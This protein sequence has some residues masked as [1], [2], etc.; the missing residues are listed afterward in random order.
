M[1]GTGRRHREDHRIRRTTT[2]DR[3]AVVVGVDTVAAEA[4]VATL[5]EVVDTT[6][7]VAVRDV[8]AAVEVAMGIVVVVGT[9]EAV[10]IEVAA[11]AGNAVGHQEGATRIEALLLPVEDI[12]D[13]PVKLILR[14]V[15]RSSLHS[16]AA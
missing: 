5:A 6:E 11:A 1:D 3:L 2:L 15:Q 10:A 9:E 13:S 7:E 4:A 14:W 16:R 8:A 12:G